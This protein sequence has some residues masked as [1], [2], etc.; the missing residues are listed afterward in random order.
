MVF[1]YALQ[2]HFFSLQEHPLL[3]WSVNISKLDMRSSCKPLGQ[4]AQMPVLPTQHLFDEG[5]VSEVQRFELP[6]PSSDF[7]MVA[8]THSSKCKDVP[9]GV[10]LTVLSKQVISRQ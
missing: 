10:E 9:D 7:G 6:N 2:L 5:F 4:W 8:V 1:D 3:P